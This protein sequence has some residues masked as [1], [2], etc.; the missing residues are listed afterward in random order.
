LVPPN[1]PRIAEINA[2]GGPD[3]VWI[4]KEVSWAVRRAARYTLFKAVCLPQAMAAHRMLRRRAIASV[5]HF[6]AVN[7]GNEALDTHAWFNAAGVEVTGYPV[8]E[9]LTEIACFVSPQRW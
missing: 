7:R 1:D 5:M 6:G 3:E 2:A 8:E 9:R 4:T